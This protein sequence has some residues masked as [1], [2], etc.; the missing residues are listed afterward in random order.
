MTGD[1]AGQI[2]LYR[3][4]KVAFDEWSW[5]P[6]RAFRAMVVTYDTQPILVPFT[7]P[8]GDT[9]DVV[10]ASCRARSQRSAQVLFGSFDHASEM[11]REAELPGLPSLPFALPAVFWFLLAR[12][13]WRFGLG[14]GCE[15]YGAFRARAGRAA[16]V[17]IDHARAG[18]S[19]A[20]VGHVV[21][22]QAVASELRRRG[23][24]GPKRPNR[25]HWSVSLYQ[26][27]A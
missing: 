14:A 15:R 8:K 11:F 17:L 24:H 21:L 16:E 25:R 5:A 7:A 6:A 4:G 1:G 13:M 9:V 20:L 3:H 12:L 23:Y 22:N 18:A 19:V 2:A 10:V 27:S 26:P